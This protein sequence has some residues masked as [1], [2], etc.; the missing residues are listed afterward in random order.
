MTKVL[1]IENEQATREMLLDCLETQGFE[2]I[3]VKS[4]SVG[5]QK[6]YEYL[7]DITICDITTPDLDG[8]RVLK[9]IRQNLSTSVMPFIFLTAKNTKAELRKVMELGADDYLVKPVTPEELLGSI[10]GRLKKQLLFKQWFAIEYQQISQS[11]SDKTDEFTNFVNLFS[12][13]PQLKKIFNFI[14]TNYHKPIS[15]RDVAKNSG[16]SSAYLTDFVRHKTGET[17]NR[18]ILRRRMIAAGIL[19]S[20]TDEPVEC[21]SRTVGYRS[22]NHFFRQF[23]QYYGNSPQAWRKQRHTNT[24]FSSKGV[25]P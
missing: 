19:L 15:L 14:D 5:V 12:S 11:S 20:E 18:W 3:G 10:K 4:G 24:L 17:I 16:F 25:K 2:A 1:V 9:L 6:A 13:Y 7:P 22:H 21:I 8:Y 23:R